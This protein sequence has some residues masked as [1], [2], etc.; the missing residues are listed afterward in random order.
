MDKMRRYCSLT[1]ATLVGAALLLGGRIYATDVTWH[2][3]T[4][5]DASISSAEGDQVVITGTKEGESKASTFRMPLSNVPDDM[6]RAYRV[7]RDRD[8][9]AAH[10]N[11]ARK[12]MDAS[13]SEEAI[14]RNEKIAN[15]KAA[16]ER[17][18]HHGKL[19][20]GHILLKKDEGVVIQCDANTPPD[21]PQSVGTVF[22]KDCP[23][24][25][26]LE[27]G[28]PVGAI[29]YED[30]KSTFNFLSIQAYSVTPP[31]VL[32]QPPSK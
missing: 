27:I 23:G 31:R 13:R 21:L 28:D 7:T 16:L 5:H 29:G 20:A 14:Q 1:K 17:D 32:A 22:L 19:V 2:G 30:G 24:I 25:R 6:I 3:G 9:E 8:R 18:P 26:K 15:L 10:T 4:W 12:Q 11:D